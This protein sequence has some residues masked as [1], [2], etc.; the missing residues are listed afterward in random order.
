VRQKTGRRY[1]GY[2]VRLSI[3]SGLEAPSHYRTKC[4]WWRLY[5]LF[6]SV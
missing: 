2:T 5:C 4:N 6:F 3:N 1:V